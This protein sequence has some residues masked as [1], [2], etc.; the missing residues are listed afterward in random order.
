V[1]RVKLAH[2]S[3]PAGSPQRRLGEILVEQGAVSA[4][5][6]EEVLLE[7]NTT[8]KRLGAMLVDRGTLS[9]PHLTDALRVQLSALGPPPSF[10]PN[11]VLRSMARALGLRPAGRVEA[12]G[13]RLPELTGD[14]HRRARSAA[15]PAHERTPHAQ[16]STRLA[17]ELA[18][19][20]AELNHIHQLVVMQGAEIA[21][22]Q[23]DAPEIAEPARDIDPEAPP[24]S[25]P[26]LLFKPAAAGG[27][28]LLGREG[29]LPAEGETLEIDSRRFVATRLGPSPLPGDRRACVYLHP[30]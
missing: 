23:A 16:V 6:L 3:L 24:T 28:E 30:V 17:D 14:L 7:Q 11:G 13:G 2:G 8:H 26:H 29:A 1:T 20:R 4:A 5:E 15:P 22:L 18:E 12:G 25:A 9:Q 21:R 19:L 10:E 27:Y